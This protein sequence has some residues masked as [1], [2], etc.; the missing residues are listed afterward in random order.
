MGIP[1]VRCS[2]QNDAI[3]VP[4]LYALD[5]YVE[6]ISVFWIFWK[7]GEFQRTNFAYIFID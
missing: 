2:R 5:Q 7:D 1:P 4:A 3:A 6:N